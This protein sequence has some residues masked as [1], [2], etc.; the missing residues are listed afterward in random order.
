LLLNG[1]VYGVAELSHARLAAGGELVFRGDGVLAAEKRDRPVFVL[2]D[3]V[4]AARSVRP[5]AVNT[6]YFSIQNKG[7][8]GLKRV[9]LS[10]DGRETGSRNCLITG[11]QKI[12]DSISFRSYKRGV[13]NLRI[14]GIDA[15]MVEVVAPSGVLPIEPEVSA[16]DM[17]VMIPEGETQIVRYTVRNTGWERQVFRLPV[18]VDETIVGIDSIGLDAGEERSRSME[19]SGARAGW[20]ELRVG[21]KGERF[22]VYRSAADAVVLDLDSLLR[23]GSGFGNDGLGKGGRLGVADHIRLPGSPSLGDMGE[24]LTMLLWVHP[25]AKGGKGM[26]DMKE[27]GGLVD[28][29]TNG[30]NHV[31]QVAGGRQ[32]TFF[33]G[34]WGRGDC[35]VDLPADWVGHW[36]MIAGV[37]GVDGLRVYIDGMQ[38]GFTPLE[39]SVHL[40]AGDNTWM[41][42]CNE[43]FP[44]QRIYTGYIRR[45]RIF[46]EALSTEDILTIYRKES[47][48]P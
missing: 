45:P 38:R 20:H 33:A 34:G 41:I 32:L 8:T 17:R 22:K 42:G 4:V 43:E 39:K 18:Q 15:G 16:V 44:G 9:V 35:T 23:D 26:M 31:L 28:I 5:G 48:N 21:D 1:R 36:H 10:V 7:A 14:G 46:Q 37:C 47:N 27:G 24:R 13:A 3:V 6:V 29:F 40:F 19:W 11:G 2:S 25:E 12:I 30:D